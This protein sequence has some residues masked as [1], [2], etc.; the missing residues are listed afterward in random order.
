MEKYKK[1]GWDKAKAA[2]GLVASV[3]IPIALAFIGHWSTDALKAREISVKYTELAIRVLSQPATEKNRPLREWA[4][5]VLNDHSGVSIKKDT[6]EFLID[7][8]LFEEQ[9]VPLFSANYAK[10]VVE[11]E[12]WKEFMDSEPSKHEQVQN[13]QEVIDA[14]YKEV[15]RAKEHFNNKST[16][17]R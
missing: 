2:S 12:A 3:L 16:K 6:K 14:F 1:D 17:S 13:I 4:T 8:S 9:W 15:T 11:S 10:L 5:D 7:N